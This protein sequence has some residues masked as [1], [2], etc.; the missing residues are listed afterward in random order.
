MGILRKDFQIISEMIEPGSRVLD[1]GCGTGELLLYLKQTKNIYSVGIEIDTDEVI[2]C[3]RKGINVIHY[4]INNGLGF[5]D[6]F[7]FD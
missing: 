7:S 1:L 5:I 2:E 3:L 6:N 4:D